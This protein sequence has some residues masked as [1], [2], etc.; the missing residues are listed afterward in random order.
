MIAQE[1]QERIA[2]GGVIIYLRKSRGDEEHDSLSNHRMV[3]EEL[4]KKHGWSY[5]IKEEYGSSDTIEFR[6]TFKEIL[7]E[8][9]PSGAYSAIVVH[10]WD[11]LSRNVKDTAIIK[12][13]LSL[14]EVLVVDKSEQVY[15]FADE[16]IDLMTDVKS[17]FAKQE[18][19]AIKKRFRAGKKAGA[20]KGHW[21]NGKAPYGYEYNHK[22]KKLI[23]DTK[24]DPS[25]ADVVKSIFKDAYEGMSMPNITYKLNRMGIPSPMGSTWSTTTLSRIM[26]QEVYLG[27]TIFGK[28][29]GS[30]HLHKKT[31]PLKVK[32]RSNWIIVN[33]AHEPLI[34]E[35]V[36]YKVRAEIDKRTVSATRSKA[37]I[38]SLTG[39]VKCGVCGYGMLIQRKENRSNL[40]K[41]CWHKDALGNKCGNKG[42]AENKLLNALMNE[43]KKYRDSLLAM[44]KENNNKGKTEELQHQIN[45]Y[46]IEVKKVKNRLSKAMEHYDDGDYTREEYIELRDKYKN[47]QKDIEAE[48][49]LLERKIKIEEQVDVS[50]KAEVL[51]KFY[52]E[53]PRLIESEDVSEEDVNRALKKFIDSIELMDKFDENNDRIIRVNFS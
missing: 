19:Q 45:E 35:D 10:D 51:D 46:K 42:I 34:N 40:I 43:I 7:E 28:S 14:N 50:D 47:H 41:P 24:G 13:T 18:L 29:S 26:K 20:L 2:Q 3:L 9:I 44:S 31:K 4:C 36:F 12:E 25:P 5:I 52:N 22:T 15:D 23:P 32:D 16:T 11:R 48:I 1:Y 8:D 21:V 39:I 30:G 17:I 6:D 38:S 49:Q 27:K 33:N 53:L 37:K